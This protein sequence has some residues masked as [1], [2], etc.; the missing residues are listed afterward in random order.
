MN[1]LIVYFTR[2][3]NT[4]RIAETIAA[5]MASNGKVKTIDF[6]R[7]PVSNL[8]ILDLLVMGCPTHKMNLPKAVNTILE[9]VPKNT[10]SN[11]PV[12]AFDTSYKMSWLLNQFTASKHLAKK[13]RKL[14]GKLIVPPEIFLVSGREGPLVEGELER[15]QDWVTSFLGKIINKG[16]Y[17]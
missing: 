13:L 6:D 2:F 16:S 1:T 10:L 7:F 8:D 15:A 11:I 4:H 12:V 3:G 14:G 17:Q 9:N 5:S